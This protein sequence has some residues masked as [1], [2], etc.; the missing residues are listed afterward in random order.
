ML[1]LADVPDQVRLLTVY[2]KLKMG[3]RNSSGQE[4]AFDVVDVPDPGA[5]VTAPTVDIAAPVGAGGTVDYSLANPSGGSRTIDV[6]FTPPA[7][8]SL[9]IA[10]I[11][12]SAQEFTLTVNGVTST[13]SSGIPVPIIAVTTSRRRHPSSRSSATARVTLPHTGESSD[14]VETVVTIA[15]LPAGSDLMTEAV[16]ISG[17]TRF[18]YDRHDRTPARHRRAHCR[19]RRSRTAT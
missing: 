6:T 12:D 7:G 8:A 3:F 17:T 16:R 14:T 9:D 4:V 5:T 13:V 10:S 11:L 18:R 15:S 19:W 2:G 1:F